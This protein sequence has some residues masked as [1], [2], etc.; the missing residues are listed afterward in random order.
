MAHRLAPEAEGEL[1]DI[2]YYIAKGS[3]SIEIAT[4]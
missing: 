1:N 2:S 4:V 3:H